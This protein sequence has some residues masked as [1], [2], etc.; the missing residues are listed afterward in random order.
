LSLVLIDY[1]KHLLNHLVTAIMALTVAHFGVV[2]T[3][4][5]C[6]DDTI[7]GIVLVFGTF[8]RFVYVIK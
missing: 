7:A 5:Y 2:R 1:S 6:L 4:Y 3:I 8:S